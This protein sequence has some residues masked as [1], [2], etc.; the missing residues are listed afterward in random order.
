MHNIQRY[1]E[2]TVER[3][4]NRIRT[5]RMYKEKMMINIKRRQR[6]RMRFSTPSYNVTFQVLYESA[7]DIPN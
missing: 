7:T 4:Y 1:V 5:G 2:R 3:G 6:E